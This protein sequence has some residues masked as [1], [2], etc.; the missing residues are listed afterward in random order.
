M[1]KGV[2]QVS[3]WRRGVR[4]AAGKNH[5]VERTRRLFEGSNETERQR[6]RIRESVTLLAEDI[7]RMPVERQ[8]LADAGPRVYGRRI[9]GAIER[10]DD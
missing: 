10:A 3:C 1:K 2:R 6:T 5:T 8:N 4:H 7:R 9:R